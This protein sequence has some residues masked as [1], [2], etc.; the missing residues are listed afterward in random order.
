MY[1]KY[2]PVNNDNQVLQ[3]NLVKQ[4]LMNDLFH[5]LDLHQ[6]QM[7]LLLFFHQE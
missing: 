4:L 2:H 7:V 5:A 1:L 6:E 3:L